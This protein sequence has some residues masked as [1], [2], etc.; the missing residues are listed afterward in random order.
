MRMNTNRTQPVPIRAPICNSPAYPISSTTFAVRVLKLENSP[1]GNTVLF[2][3]TIITAI[4]SP[5][6][7]PAPR[8]TD[9][10]TEDFAAGA[11]TLNTASECVAPSALAPA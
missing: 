5:I 6:A 7:R 4:V 1:D 2:P 3:A 11:T 10:T 9:A 8:I